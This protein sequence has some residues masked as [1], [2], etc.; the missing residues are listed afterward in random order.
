MKLLYCL[1]LGRRSFIDY[2]HFR[3]L[4]ENSQHPI[5]RLSGLIHKTVDL[6]AEFQ[7]HINTGGGTGE[8]SLYPYL[9]KMYDL[10]GE[11][12]QWVAS[13]GEE[14]KYE[15][16][17]SILVDKPSYLQNLMTMPGAPDRF[18]IY[19]DLPLAYMWNLYRVLRIALHSA[20]LKSTQPDMDN[21]TMLSSEE[22]SFWT[23]RS[24][25]DELCSSVYSYF[26]IPVAGRS[27]TS[28][29]ES[30]IGLRQFFL[31]LPLRISMNTLQTLPTNPVPRE[32]WRWVQHVVLFLFRLNHM[33]REAEQHSQI[34]C[35]GIED[36]VPL[37]V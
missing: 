18:I 1:L 12:F 33:G 26:I 11:L 8:A 29:T 16:H 6:I 27:E 35:Y 32:R 36:D 5:V 13:L 14:S 22:E 34:G 15:G 4:Y 10:D 9:R 20:I 2:D 31:L 23:I 25:F 37:C 21:E 24:E 19:G 3:E 17:V 7:E 30:L 28:D